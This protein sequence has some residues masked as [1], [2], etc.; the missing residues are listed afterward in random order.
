MVG[1]GMDP[2]ERLLSRVVQERSGHGRYLGLPGS[3]L[4]FSG[5][6]LV[7]VIAVPLVRTMRLVTSGSP[8]EGAVGV[9]TVAVPAAPTSAPLVSS[10]APPVAVVPVPEPT[11]TPPVARADNYVVQSGD[12]LQ[13]IAARYDLR[14]ATLASINQLDQPELLQPGRSLVVPPTD[15]VVH[16]VEPGETLRAIAEQYGVDVERII[17]ANELEDPDHIAVGLRLFIPTE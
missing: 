7:L 4:L 10:Q 9:S 6:V 5:L 3:W 16:V 8:G 1:H 12:S 14:P 11:V 2:N 13:S 17:S 15:G